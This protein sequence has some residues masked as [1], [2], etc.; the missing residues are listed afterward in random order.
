MKML[1]AEHSK[2]LQQTR[3]THHSVSYP[4]DFRFVN[5]W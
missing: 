5:V 1:R 3:Y 4:F 2:S